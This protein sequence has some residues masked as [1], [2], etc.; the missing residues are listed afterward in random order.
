MTE[1]YT[2][3]SKLKGGQLKISDQSMQ[4]E[5]AKAIQE[6]GERA[7]EGGV[8]GVVVSHPSR[9]NDDTLEKRKRAIF[10]LL[11]QYR[12]AS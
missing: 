4:N 6:L 1:T 8:C 9:P 12:S 2:F 10:A 3:L 11:Q 7:G 5:I